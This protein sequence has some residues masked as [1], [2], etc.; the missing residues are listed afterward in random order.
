M[1][2][3]N[4]RG[5]AIG[6]ESWYQN[7]FYR[8]KCTVEKI[9]MSSFVCLSVYLVVSNTLGTV[10]HMRHCYTAEQAIRRTVSTT[11]TW[12]TLRTAKK[13]PTLQPPTP[14]PNPNPW[15]PHKLFSWF[16]FRFNSPPVFLS[17]LGIT[18]SIGHQAYQIRRLPSP[19]WLSRV[20]ANL[21]PVHI[22]VLFSST[23]LEIT[24]TQRFDTSEWWR[25]S[26][27]PFSPV[28]SCWP[29]S[30]PEVPKIRQVPSYEAFPRPWLWLVC[31]VSHMSVVCISCLALCN[32][33]D[34]NTLT[35]LVHDNSHFCN[36]S[37]RT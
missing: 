15:P 12:S 9:E 5:P 29:R 28:S 21:L 20:E 16:Y 18:D 1:K 17:I 8:G 36:T 34:C 25:P 14:I 37:N 35:I 23:S 10:S 33:D 22:T 13:S 6:I 3:T 30:Y 7:I 31:V 11:W 27:V 19:S 4:E 32:Q 2:K 24:R 26:P